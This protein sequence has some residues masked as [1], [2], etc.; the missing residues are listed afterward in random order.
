VEI[1]TPEAAKMMA[2]WDEIAEQFELLAQRKI[3]LLDAITSLANSKDA[4]IAGRKVTRVQREGA[5]SYARVVKDHC[6]KV[7]LEPYRGKP[8][9]YWKVS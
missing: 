2:E 4:V 6:P 3:D 1:D 8:S 7:D 9:S 5:V